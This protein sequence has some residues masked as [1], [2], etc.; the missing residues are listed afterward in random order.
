ML[1]FS[2]QIPVAYDSHRLKW[3][4][5]GLTLQILGYNGISKGEEMWGDN[6]QHGEDLS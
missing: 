4:W 3:I 6:A 5:I 2:N 1:S